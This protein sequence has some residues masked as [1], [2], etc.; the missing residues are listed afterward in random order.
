MPK[1]LIERTVPGAGAMTDA[2]LAELSRTS[3]AVLG[4]MGGR[5]QWLE[6]Y[7]TE[8]KITCVYLATDPE[9][10]REHGARGGFPVDSIQRVAT[11]IDPSTAEPARVMGAAQ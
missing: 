10:L 2:E 11:I 3:V 7:V 4:D 8:D 6:S 9:A 5:A 1:Y